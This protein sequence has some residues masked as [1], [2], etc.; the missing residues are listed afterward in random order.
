[1]NRLARIILDSRIS[2]D[3]LA[4]KSGLNVDRLASIAAGE[5]ASIAESRRIAS[6]LSIPL[7]FILLPSHNQERVELLFRRNLREKHLD[8]NLI[9][10]MSTRIAYSLELLEPTGQPLSDIRIEKLSFESAEYAAEQF[11]RLF[12]E[13][14]QVRPLMD[15]PEIATDE[16][17]VL[18]FVGNLKSFDGASAVIDEQPFVFVSTRF[19]PRMLFTLAHEIGHLVQHNV[20][21]GMSE[22]FAI[23]E[24]SAGSSRT[25]RS[26]RVGEAFADSFASCLLLPK[27]GL[28]HALR[29]IRD[30]FAVRQD[31]IGDVEL[32]CLSRIFGVSFQVAARRCEDL[33]LLPSGGAVSLYEQLRKDYGSPEKRAQELSIPPRL[34]MKFSA[35]PERLLRAAIRRIRDGEI[36]I[37][38][39]SGLLGVSMPDLIAANAPLAH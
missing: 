30:V 6:A 19:Q 27:L 2:L 25:V 28:A 29:A 23:L 36:S 16:L 12:C 1:M 17:D 4:T 14:D 7:S 31:A 35:L 22:S 24:R 33:D 32:L 39:A 34:E 11:R 37:G 15:L 18:L 9:D 20:A 3:K 10:L 26:S 13:D 5:E 21:Q 38:K 8:P